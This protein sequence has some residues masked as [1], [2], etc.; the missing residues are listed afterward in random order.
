MM[1]LR[2]VG[3]LVQVLP[4]P[5]SKLSSSSYRSVSV[6]VQGSQRLRIDE[7]RTG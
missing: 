6:Y 3:L 7:C 1:K 2:T 5:I 4:F